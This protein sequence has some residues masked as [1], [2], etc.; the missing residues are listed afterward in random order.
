M[1][2]H[3]FERV[4]GRRG[5][6]DF[7]TLTDR[8]YAD[9]PRYVPTPRQQIRR[10]WRDGVPMYVLCVTPPAPWPGGPRCT[11]TATSTPSSAA[12][13]SCSGSPSSPRRPPVRCSTRSPRT[14]HPAGICCSGRWRCCPTRP[15]A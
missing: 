2:G 4:T 13:A 3:R 8:L 5:L 12:G 10:W 9:E 15:A 14:P 7:L 1:T 11:P 6:R